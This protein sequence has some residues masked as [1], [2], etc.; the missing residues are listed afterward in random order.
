MPLR[1]S[2]LID[3][4]KELTFEYQGWRIRCALL[5]ASD[6]KEYVVRE[7][8]SKIVRT[9]LKAGGVLNIR[10]FECD[11]VRAVKTIRE[12]ADCIVRAS[13]KYFQSRRNFFCK[14]PEIPRLPRG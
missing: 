7:Q 14:K 9:A 5:P 10:D 11:A 4:A 6:G 1:A 13:A 12:A 3:G 2:T 8:Y